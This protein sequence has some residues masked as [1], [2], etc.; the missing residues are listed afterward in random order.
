MPAQA[1]QLEIAFL[2]HRLEVIE[3]WPDSPR[4]AA[5]RTAIL[6]RLEMLPSGNGVVPVQSAHALKAGIAR[7]F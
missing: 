3:S 4:K 5:T 6:H 7:P 2:E 1:L